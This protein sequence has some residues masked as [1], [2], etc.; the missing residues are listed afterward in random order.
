MY[1]TFVHSK[2]F[3]SNETIKQSM[4]FVVNKKMKIKSKANDNK[5]IN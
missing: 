3:I 5:L 1:V 4:I 2:A